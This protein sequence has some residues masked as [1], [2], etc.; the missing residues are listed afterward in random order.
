[1][2]NVN[3]GFTHLVRGETRKTFNVR[4]PAHAEGPLISLRKQEMG[5]TGTLSHLQQAP[6]P[7]AKLRH[8]GFSECAL[9]ER[10]EV[11]TRHA[12]SR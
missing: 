1:M 10:A 7:H 5:S 11:E 12:E 2:Y 4:F 6:R 3:S 8:G 9:A